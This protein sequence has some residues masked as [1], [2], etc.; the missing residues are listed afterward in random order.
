MISL[1]SFFAYASAFVLGAVFILSSGSTLAGTN[2]PFVNPPSGSV[3]PSFMSIESAKDITVGENLKVGNSIQPKGG[4][5]TLL[6]DAANVA[7]K[8]NFEAKGD[9]IVG[10]DVLVGGSI[11]PKTGDSLNIDAANANFSGNAIINGAVQIIGKTY[12]DGGIV[13][14]NGL[15]VLSDAK[16][17][18]ELADPTLSG[19]TTASQ[20]NVTGGANIQKLDVT[21]DVTAQNNVLMKKNATIWGT[22]SVGNDSNTGVFI[23]PSA[24]LL[25]NTL[26]VQGKTEL[27]DDV[28]IFGKLT[29]TQ[30]I[31]KFDYSLPSGVMTVPSGATRSA[32]S[33]CATGTMLSCTIAPPP[34]TVWDPAN[35]ISSSS[36]IT[37]PIDWQTC[38]VYATNMGAGSVKFAAQA[39]CFDP[40]KN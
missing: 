11:K 10:K 34:N 24:T 1:R 13:V 15:K 27:K 8:N 36:F 32:S 22:F 30:S 37:G 16:N 17:K 20:L 7:I 6:L 28:K 18:I 3:N 25:K 14:K 19:T 23:S 35:K 2:P 39:I 33:K 31:G 26:T 40:A 9:G 5:T 4:G 29:A 38:S 12:I 21:D